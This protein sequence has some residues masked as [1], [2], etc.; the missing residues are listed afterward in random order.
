MELHRSCSKLLNCDRHLY[1]LG[2]AKLSST[3]SCDAI[4]TRLKWLF[5]PYGYKFFISHKFTKEVKNRNLPFSSIGNIIDP[6]AIQMKI[7]REHLLEMA[8][9]ILVSPGQKSETNQDKKTDINDA[10]KYIE[11]LRDNVVVDARTVFGASHEQNCQDLVAQWWSTFVAI[12]CHWLLDD[13]TNFEHLYKKI[14]LIPETLAVL[15][16]P[17]PKAIV[18]AF[19]ARKDYLISD[20]KVAPRKIL[21]QCDYASHLLADSLTLT[22]CKKKDNLVLLAQLVVCDWLLETRT[23]LWEDSVDDG[24]KAPVSNYVLT[25]FQADLSS[26]RSIAEHIPHFFPFVM[27]DHLSFSDEDMEELL[28]Y[29]RTTDAI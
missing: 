3:N 23:S 25:T 26:V 12:A 14:E 21:Q 13:E 29:K 8:M 22:S 11:L 4:P 19:I 18:A 28:Y 9:Q 7:Y 1:Y 6:L 16:D 15:N 2:L 24:L 5:T 27:S 17:L 20:R 10:L